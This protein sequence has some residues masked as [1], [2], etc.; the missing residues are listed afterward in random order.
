MK[1]RI[2]IQ[3]NQ[4]LQVDAVLFFIRIV[5][6][7]AFIFHGWGKIQNPLHWMGEE[8]SFPAVFQLLAAISEFGGGIVLIVGFLTCLGALGIGCTMFVAVC[9]HFFVRGDPF[10]SFTGGASYELALVY[11]SIA[12]LFLILGPGRFSLDGKIFRT[13]S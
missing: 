10:V 9:K 11:F 8:S 13:T 1:T 3:L 5:C 4:P 12:L 7:C 6:G 2:F